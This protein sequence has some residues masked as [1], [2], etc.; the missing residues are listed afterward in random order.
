MFDPWVR[1]I[2]WRREGFPG[3]SAGKESACNA[4][5]QNTW[6]LTL[7]WEDPVEKDMATHS[8]DSCLENPMDR[9]AWRTTVH[10]ATKSLSTTL[11]CM[12]AQ[13]CPGR[14]K[15]AIVWDNLWCSN[16]NQDHFYWGSRERSLSLVDFVLQITSQSI[17]CI[18]VWCLPQHPHLYLCILIPKNRPGGLEEALDR[19]L[20]NH[21]RPMPLNWLQPPSKPFSLTREAKHGFCCFLHSVDSPPLPSTLNALNPLLPPN[22]SR[23]CPTVKAQLKILSPTGSHCVLSSFFFFFFLATPQNLSFGI[24]V[25]RP[26][27][28]RSQN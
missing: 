20:S 26:G 11:V 22:I 17:A 6:V 15:V 13:S 18:W 1:K 3:D 19:R 10:G 21:M 28:L 9:G 2:P 14:A 7:G 24:L 12:M 5:P 16:S 4:E 23:S 27:K 25:S 8:Q